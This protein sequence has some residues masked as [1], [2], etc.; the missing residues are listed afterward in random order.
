MSTA[1]NYRPMRRVVTGLDSVGRS[2]VVSHAASANSSIAAEYGLEYL[3]SMRL[4]AEVAGSVD[5]VPALGDDIDAGTIL[6]R[7]CTIAPGTEIGCHSTDAGDWDTILSGSVIRSL[8]DSEVSLV[9]GD[10]VVHPNTLHNWR[11]LGSSPA[12]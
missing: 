11:N 2:C 6:G 1:T 3:W 8:E 4:R 12:S 10:C 7:R 9:A 5:L